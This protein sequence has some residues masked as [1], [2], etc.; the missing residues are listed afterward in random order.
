MG[1]KEVQR[2]PEKQLQQK[3]EVKEREVQKQQKT[4][5]KKQKTRHS[6]GDERNASTT[7]II[8]EEE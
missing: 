2:T 4:Q 3:E 6:D 5:Q 8:F 7:C 1:I